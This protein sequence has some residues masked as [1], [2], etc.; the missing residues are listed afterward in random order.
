M[1]LLGVLG[2]RNA[3]RAL[4]QAPAKVGRRTRRGPG[5][6]V[7]IESDTSLKVI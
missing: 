6:G 2:W 1:A 7:P 5:Y 3:P 4:T